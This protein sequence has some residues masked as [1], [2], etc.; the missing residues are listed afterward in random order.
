MVKQSQDTRKI[1][2]GLEHPNTLTS[3]ANLA[4]I[5]RN[6]GW[7]KEA[8]SLKVQVINTRKTLAVLLF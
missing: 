2:L 4:S 3:M 6:H 1:L 8:E 7:W 5:Y